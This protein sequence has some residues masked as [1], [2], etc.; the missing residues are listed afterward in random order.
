MREHDHEEKQGRQKM[1]RAREKHGG[2]PEGRQQRQSRD[3]DRG[4]DE[5]FGGWLQKAVKRGERE[6][7]PLPSP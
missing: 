1:A 4:A 7:M 6:T 3:D 2:A 5:S